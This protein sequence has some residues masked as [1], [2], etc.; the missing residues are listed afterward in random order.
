MAAGVA[1][2]GLARDAV[3]RPVPDRGTARSAAA[4]PQVAAPRLVHRR[5]AVARH[6]PDD[7]AARSPRVACAAGRRI[8]PPRWPG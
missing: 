1:G 7:H 4:D 8:S 5:R 6:P 2:A 3:P